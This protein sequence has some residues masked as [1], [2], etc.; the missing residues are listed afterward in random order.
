MASS[1]TPTAAP[2]P[3][4][5]PSR[6]STTSLQTSKQADTPAP[7]PRPHAT[8]LAAGKD[9]VGE[10]LIREKEQAEKDAALQVEIKR[11]KSP[12]ATS[13][14]A[15]SKQGGGLSEQAGNSKLWANTDAVSS[16]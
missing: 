12:D 4:Q 5:D 1:N 10:A 9:R 15:R 11:E 13:A 2:L 8:G 16:S 6:L 3:Q 14:L 7:P